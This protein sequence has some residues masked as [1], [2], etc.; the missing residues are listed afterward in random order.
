[1]TQ[2]THNHIQ[3]KSL[4]FF[5]FLIT[6]LNLNLSSE[7]LRRGLVKYASNRRAESL[8]YYKDVKQNLTFFSCEK[9]EPRDAGE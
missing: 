8:K 1:M 3:Y 4:P 2:I 9:H 5:F 6:L 7:R